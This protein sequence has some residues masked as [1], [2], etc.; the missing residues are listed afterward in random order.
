MSLSWITRRTVALGGIVIL[1]LATASCFDNE[2]QQRKAFIAVLQTRIIDKPGLHIPILSELEIADLGSYAD[3]Y[4][5]MS[6]F[7][8]ELDAAL[9][10]S[11]ARAMEIGS[12]RSLEDLANHAAIV[13]V[14]TGGMARMK[15]ELDK[16][17]GAADAAHKALQQPADL[18]PVYDIAYRRMVTEPARIYREL[19]PVIESSLPA[20]GELAVYL[21]D[22]RSVIELHGNT[23]NA[24]DPAVR[25]KLTALLQAASK[26]GENSAK[27][28]VMLR[29]LVEGK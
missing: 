3:Q 5:I 4:R 8:H 20:I 26:A 17:E 29:A 18:K 23:L 10:Q 24:N 2:P 16:A 21:H 1:A 19:V 14:V 9:S 13:P 7:H 15:S 27:G 6:G 25:A 11:L 28:K 12:P 22:H